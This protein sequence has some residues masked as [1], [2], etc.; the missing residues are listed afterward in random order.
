MTRFGRLIHRIKAH[1]LQRDV[2]CFFLAE[3][4]VIDDLEDQRLMEEAYGVAPAVIDSKYYSPCKRLRSY[5][6]SV[7]MV[8]STNCGICSGHIFLTIACPSAYVTV[9]WADTD[10][11][12]R[13][14]IKCGHGVMPGRRLGPPS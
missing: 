14:P 6:T 10:L 9:E 2:P 11:K 8:Q 13:K 7:S 1:P 12:C 3:N 4:V 5:F